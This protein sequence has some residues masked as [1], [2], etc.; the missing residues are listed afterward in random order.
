MGRW[1]FCGLCLAFTACNVHE[2][3]GTKLTYAVDSDSK[4]AKQIDMER[5]FRAVQKRVAGLGTA[6]LIGDRVWVGIYGSKQENVE[7]V[8]QLLAHAGVLEFRIVADDRYAAA[9]IELAGE[10]QFADKRELYENGS[11]D[12]PKA[13]WC[14]LSRSGDTQ[15][16]GNPHFATRQRESGEVEMLVLI[17]PY[18]VVGADLTAANPSNDRSGRPS[19]SF[20]LNQSGARRFGKL[21]SENLPDPAYA[22]LKRHLAIILDDVVMSAPAINSKIEDR[23]EITGRFTQM[24][25]E[26]ISAVLTADVLPA[27]LKLLD[28]AL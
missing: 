18:N 14:A 1:L 13:R 27:R 10:P 25:V 3:V 16:T 11:E 17:D 8:K 28:E 2:P 9:L 7:R 5:V 12:V 4:D 20:T 22:D 19:V 26:D 24:E 23:G 21:T 6:K 15:L